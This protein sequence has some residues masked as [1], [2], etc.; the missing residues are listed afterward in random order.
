MLAPLAPLQY[1]DTTFSDRCYEMF[2]KGYAGGSQATYG[3]FRVISENP[4]TKRSDSGG[5]NWHHPGLVARHF[6]REVA[7]YVAAQAAD[8]FGGAP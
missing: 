7:D 2:E 8:V 5:A 1:I 6:V 4:A 3:S